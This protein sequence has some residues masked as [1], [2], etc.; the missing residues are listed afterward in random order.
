[1]DEHELARIFE[2]VVMLNQWAIAMLGGSIAILVASWLRRPERLWVRCTFLLLPTGWWCVAQTLLAGG[3]IYRTYRVYVT[4]RVTSPTG[5]G[6]RLP[7]KVLLDA[8]QSIGER[9]EFWLQLAFVFMGLWL[10][11]L[12]LYWV[13]G[14]EFGAQPIIPSDAAR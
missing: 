11:L 12:V 3:E 7:M 8:L 10:L 6:Q 14:K 5:G 4:V 2:G 13:F 1:M 9:Q